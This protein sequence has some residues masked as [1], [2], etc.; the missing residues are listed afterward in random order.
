MLIQEQQMEIVVI[1]IQDQ[2][3]QNLVIRD[4]LLDQKQHILTQEV[5]RRNQLITNRRVLILGQEA[6]IQSLLVNQGIRILHRKKAL[7]QVIVSLQEAIIKV[8]V[9]GDHRVGEALELDQ[10]QVDQKEGNQ[11]SS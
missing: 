10:Q 2:L 9:Q 5:Q 4:Q 11:F 1:I 7:N 8:K 3:N 6:H